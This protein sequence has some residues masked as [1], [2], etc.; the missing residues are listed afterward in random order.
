MVG[1]SVVLGTAVLGA[2]VV[3]A[4]DVV[5]AAAG[6]AGPNPAHCSVATSGVKTAEAPTP[7]AGLMTGSAR[8]G[9]VT[10]HES[11]ATHR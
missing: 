2:V 11:A 8:A 5:T 1:T 6:L 3:A 7:C 9:S 10:S 4:V